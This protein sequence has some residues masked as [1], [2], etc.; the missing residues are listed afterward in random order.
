VGGA[1][2]GTTEMSA[3]LSTASNRQTFISSS[4]TFLRT[5][6]FDGLDL[7]FEYPGSGNSPSS[8]KQLF[9]LLVQVV[10]MHASA[11]LKSFR[12]VLLLNRN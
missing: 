4:I 6:G 11:E 5:K 3:M 2:A 12:A 1:T 8:D 7:D 10:M 9:T